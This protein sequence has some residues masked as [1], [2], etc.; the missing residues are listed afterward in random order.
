M[1]GDRK[2]ACW[3]GLLVLGSRQGRRSEGFSRRKTLPSSRFEPERCPEFP[4]T[5]SQVV[6]PD[7]SPP[8]TPAGPH[9]TSRGQSRPRN[10]LEHRDPAGNRG[11]RPCKNPSVV[12]FN[13]G[14]ATFA[15]HSTATDPVRMRCAIS[16]RQVTSRGHPPLEIEVVSDLA[17]EPS[18]RPQ[19]QDRVDQRLLVSTQRTNIENSG[20][21]INDE[22]FSGA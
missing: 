10:A 16:A 17:V 12:Q 20:A 22:V 7:D 2:G 1:V 4:A 6:E 3:M 9:G 15:H 11:K 21:D 19:R 18:L 14:M 5:A 8:Q 13:G